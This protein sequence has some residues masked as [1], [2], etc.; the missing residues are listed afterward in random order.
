MNKV[1]KYLLI[2]LGIN[3]G[4]ATLLALPILSSKGE[5]GLVWLLLDAVV[6]GIALLVQLIVGIVW[7]AGSTKRQLGQAMLIAVGIVFVVGLSVC[8]GGAFFH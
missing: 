4:A 7:A 6:M 2:T 8:T 3:L 1:V 5:D